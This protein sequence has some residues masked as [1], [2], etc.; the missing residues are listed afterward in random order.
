MA[1]PERGRTSTMV[2]L[3][4]GLLI[5]AGIVMGLVMDW[6]K[7]PDLIPIPI[8]ERGTEASEA[9]RAPGYRPRQS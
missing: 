6:I 3:T 7:H 2:A 9:R 1:A 8:S 4:L 5:G